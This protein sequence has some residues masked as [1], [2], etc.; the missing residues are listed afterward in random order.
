MNIKL[1]KLETINNYLQLPEKITEVEGQLEKC[2]LQLQ[3]TLF[4]INMNPSSRIFKGELHS[5][6]QKTKKL[7]DRKASL[8]QLLIMF[9][10]AHQ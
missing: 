2:N 7:E 10:N 1:N 4:M 6:L 9:N 8:N 3:K 5:L